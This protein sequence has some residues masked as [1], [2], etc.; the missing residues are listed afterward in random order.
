MRLAEM[1]A[2]G[3]V[4][5]SFYNSSQNRMANIAPKIVY[6]CGIKNIKSAADGF[7]RLRYRMMTR[8]EQVGIGIG[9]FAE[10]NPNALRFSTSSL[11][12][13]THFLSWG[14]SLSLALQSLQ[15]THELSPTISICDFSFFFF[16]SFAARAFLHCRWLFVHKLDLQKQIQGF[17]R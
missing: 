9:S 11:T 15:L 5:T 12:E 2:V 3:E 1:P 8:T 13:A 17:L 4:F 7:F 10:K 14:Q 6:C 16:S